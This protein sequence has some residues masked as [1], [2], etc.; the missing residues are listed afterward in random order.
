MDFENHQ[1]RVFAPDF[2]LEGIDLSGANFTRASVVCGRFYRAK[3]RGAL[4]EDANLYRAEFVEADLTRARFT[5]ADVSRASFVG[6]DLTGTVFGGANFDGA[7]AAPKNASVLV[8]IPNKYGK[9][10]SWRISA[11]RHQ[12]IEG[13]TV[14]RYH[15]HPLERFFGPGECTLEEMS[16][17]FVNA[18]AK[19]GCREAPYYLRALDILERLMEGE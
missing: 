1:N 2:S 6:A 3:L 8:P 10:R 15:T 13:G 12:L 14:D 17:H 16:A 5:V 7:I 11:Y 9:T 19:H 4:F 18:Q